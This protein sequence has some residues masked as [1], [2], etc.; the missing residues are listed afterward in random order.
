[1]TR[2]RP[3]RQSILA[4]LD[5]LRTHLAS[6]GGMP[7]PPAAADIWEEILRADSHHSTAIEGN[8]LTAAQV[9]S[10]L[11][12]GL[13]S[14]KRDVAEYLEVIAYANAA[15]WVYE[16]AVD[17]ASGWE[18]TEPLTLVEVR[19]I[20][21]RVCELPWMVRPPDQ[22]DPDEM[23]GSFRRH[24]IR[25]FASGMRPPPW[26]DAP[27]Q[28]RDWLG[29]V[30]NPPPEGLHA[31]EHLASL[32]AEF[33]RIHPFRD[34][35]GRTGRLLLSLQLVRLGYAPA[36]VLNRERGR[37]LGALGRADRGDLG[38][39]AALIAGA[40]ERSMERF[41]IPAAAAEGD[42]VPVRAL[43]SETISEAAILQAIRR[44]RMRAARKDGRWHSTRTWLDEYL[45][46]R[47][48]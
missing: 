8:T 45:A 7:P 43:A 4:R 2:G 48:S 23:P 13:A 5:A 3:P 27:A 12:E 34:G 10:L 42:L 15:R 47:G 25:T 14:G 26:T 28:V 39:L 6:L 30:G 24:D 29:R 40:V 37:Y 22:L 41:L 17:G 9:R 35:N 21:R 11:D 31:I 38:P 16:H 36:V 20:H 18:M 33:E 44:G 1:M 46:S 32:H 19:E